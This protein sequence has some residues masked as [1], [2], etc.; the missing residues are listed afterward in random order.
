MSAYHRRFRRLDSRT[1]TA[2]ASLF[3]SRPSR[4]NTGDAVAV[5]GEWLAAVSSIYNVPNPS[6]RIVTPAE[7]AGS[8]CYLPDTDAILLPHP[9][10][11]TLLH[12]FRHHLQHHG[13]AM[14]PSRWEPP[15]LRHEEDARAW[16]LSLYHQV[17]P[18][19]FARLVGEGQIFY[20]TTDDMDPDP[21][22]SPSTLDS[23][24]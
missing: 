3:A 12:E 13:A 7:C 5:M 17:R 15:A 21:V 19:L 22:G 14:I 10:V 23:G 6:L 4:L 24:S 16:S 18:R 11:T 1:L 8:G 9:S 2:T 20:V